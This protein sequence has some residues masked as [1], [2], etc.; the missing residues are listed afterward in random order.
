MGGFIHGKDV[1]ASRESLFVYTGIERDVWSA[2]SFP[3]C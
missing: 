3:L 1:I 2:V